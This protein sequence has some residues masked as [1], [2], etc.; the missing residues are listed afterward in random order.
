M[1]IK[2]GTCCTLPGVVLA[3]SVTMLKPKLGQV[4]RKAPRN[5]MELLELS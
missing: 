4:R 2:E 3:I 5:L 1:L